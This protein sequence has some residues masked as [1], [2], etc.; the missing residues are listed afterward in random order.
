ML[1]GC[2]CGSLRLRVCHAPRTVTNSLLAHC[3]RRLIN[4]GQSITA[5]H[6][7]AKASACPVTAPV[8]TENIWAT[9]SLFLHL[10]SVC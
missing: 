1:L 4:D 10:L 5:N 3:S 8:A 9:N 7:Q 2:C 6:R